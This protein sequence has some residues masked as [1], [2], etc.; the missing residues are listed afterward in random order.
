MTNPQQIQIDVSPTGESKLQ[1]FG[2]AGRN[3]QTASRFL[4]QALGHKT[5]ESF[6][7]EYFQSTVSQ[8][9]TQPLRDSR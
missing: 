2:F 3:C 8:Q 1:T 4:E 5:A 9:Q 6:T 7:P